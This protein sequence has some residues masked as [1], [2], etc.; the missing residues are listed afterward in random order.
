VEAAEGRDQRRQLIN[1]EQPVGGRFGGGSVRLER[2]T[3]TMG[4]DPNR[5]AGAPMNVGSDHKPSSRVLSAPGGASSFALDDG[6]GADQF[7]RGEGRGANRRGSRSQPV[8]GKSGGTDPFSR[9][10]QPQHHQGMQRRQASP[11]SKNYGQHAGVMRT[12]PGQARGMAA[13][14]GARS[15]AGGPRGVAI[16]AVPPG[17]NPNNS[18]IHGGIFG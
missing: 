11:R 2:G 5:P 3:P 8:G 1:R 10:G 17:S 12:Q 14:G 4:I 6:S 16:N 15:G 18:S 9:A 7:G 13:G